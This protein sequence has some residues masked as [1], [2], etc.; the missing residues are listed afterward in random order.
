MS[1]EDIFIFKGGQFLASFSLFL[2]FL[3]CNWYINW[4]I[5]LADDGV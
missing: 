3:L 5:N 2:S 4:L 1:L